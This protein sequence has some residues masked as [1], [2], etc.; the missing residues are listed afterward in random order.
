MIELKV[1]KNVVGNGFLKIFCSVKWL[2]YLLEG[3]KSSSDKVAPESMSSVWTDSFKIESF[4]KTFS[5]T[6]LMFSALQG[7]LI[8][9]YGVSFVLFQ[10][11]K[12][13]QVVEIWEFQDTNLLIA[14]W[15]PAPCNIRGACLGRCCLDSTTPVFKHT[16]LIIQGAGSQRA[17]IK[18]VSQI[19]CLF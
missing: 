16:L 7:F 9:Q 15:L 1:T 19:E 2:Q 14:L 12:F 13:L 8:P 17:G 18:L 6:A 4:N 10:K 3:L 5:K 11:N